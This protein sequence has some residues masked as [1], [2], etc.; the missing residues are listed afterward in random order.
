M[1]WFKFLFPGCRAQ[2]EDAP[3]FTADMNQHVV[4]ETTEVDSVVYTLQ[5]NATD[6]STIDDLRFYI[7]DTQVF[8]VNVTSGQVFLSQPLD[9][10][11]FSAAFYNMLLST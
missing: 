5:A 2:Q 9:R 3:S 6:N 11:V 10:E 4:S 7:R 8:T 1:F